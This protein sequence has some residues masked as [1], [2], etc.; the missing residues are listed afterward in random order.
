MQEIL[1]GLLSPGVL[2]KFIL[3]LSQNEAPRWDI[4]RSFRNKKFISNPWSSPCVA[5]RSILCAVWAGGP[6]AQWIMA[7]A[8]TSD[9]L[10]LI[11][12]T[13]VSGEI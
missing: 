4:L 1:A 9:S 2:G 13:K 7:L 5:M 8:A 3:R 6:M 11:L 10:R 12:T